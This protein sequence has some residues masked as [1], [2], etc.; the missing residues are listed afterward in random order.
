MPK[1]G[2][3]QGNGGKQQ[4]GDA[5]AASESSPVSS[6]QATPQKSPDAPA[7]PAAAEQ[8]EQNPPPSGEG[9]QG[10][11]KSKALPD[12][13]QAA[14]ERKLQQRPEQESIR[15]IVKDGGKLS[16]AKQSLQKE[17]NKNA[18]N[19]SL[20]ARAAPEDLHKAGVLLHD[21]ER[22]APVLQGT[23]RAL[24]KKLISKALNVKLQDRVDPSEFQQSPLNRGGDVA[25][26]LRAAKVALQ[27]KINRDTVGHLLEQRP[28][29]E[30]LEGQC[31]GLESVAS[32]MGFSILT[33]RLSLV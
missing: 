20:E 11:K 5:A 10:G 3:K 30:E 7:T 8:K 25:P 29:I 27:H 1:K 13:V 32:A 19:R 17:L 4:G 23:A 14:L 16:G 15:A 21:S 18:L 9:K 2:A 22:V 24:E 6:P 26:S 28:G 33:L 12:D 31:K